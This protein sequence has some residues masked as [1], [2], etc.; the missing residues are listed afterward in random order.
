[1]EFKGIIPAMVTPLDRDEELNEAALRQLVN[2]L[3][4]GGV[5]GLFPVGSQGEF[6]GFTPD[7]KQ[8]IWEIVVEET[9]GRVPVYAGT[10]AITTREV[11]ALNKRAERAGVNA[12]SVITPYFIHPSQEELYRHYVAI[13][14]A[15]TLPVILYNNPGRTGGVNLSAD[16]VARLAEHPNIVG[17]KDSSGDFSLTAEYIRNTGDDFAV[18]LG[19]DTLIYAGLVHGAKGSITATANV[20]PS[21][22]VEIYE[23]FI[24]GDLDRALQ[25]QLRLAPLRLAFGLGTFPVVVKEALEMIGILAGPARSPVG[26]MSQAN[27]DKLKAVLQ[28]M[29]V[30]ERV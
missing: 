30:L 11:I 25:A 23:A 8:R 12:V 27:R 28:E 18:L 21:L 5:H 10:G 15:T 22:V 26:P 1:M 17:I 29:G 16:L 19:R 3:I 2:H 13:A 20:V 24:A 9:A 7:E 14:E 4:D 6:Y